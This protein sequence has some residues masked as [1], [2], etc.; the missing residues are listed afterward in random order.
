[1]I[2][3]NKGGAKPG[4]TNAAKGKIF[5]AQLRVLIATD[6]ME[7]PEKKRRLRKAAEQLL[8]QAAKGHEWAIKELANR[9]DGKATQGV[10]L[11]NPD[12]TPVNFFDVGMLRGMSQKELV[13]LKELLAKAGTLSK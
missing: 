3:R 13:S 7:L 12:G 5:L 2:E 1:M 8:N 6:E 9:L 10:E 11:A 4:N